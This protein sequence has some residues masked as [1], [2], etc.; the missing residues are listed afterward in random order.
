[1]EK[2][3]TRAF[4]AILL[5]HKFP[6]GTGEACEFAIKRYHKKMEAPI[7]KGEDARPSECWERWIQND[8]GLPGIQLPAG[9]WYKARLLIHEWLGSWRL[10]D[11][12]FSNGS[13]YF[14]T[15]G[16][17]SIEA[18][19]SA[20]V[21]ASTA[22]NF[23]NF[24]RLC[25][26]HKAL[27]R[28]A[29]NRFSTL[30]RKRGD[31]ARSVDRYLWNRFK[32]AKN[33]GFLCF[34][35]KL[36]LVTKIVHGSRFSTVPKNNEKVRPINIE[37]FANI[38][39]QKQVGNGIRQLLKTTVGID[40]DTLALEHRK[41]IKDPS[42]A[43]I[44]LS[45]ASDSVSIE[46][47]KFLFPGW[48][49][50]LLED[51]RSHMVLGP[52][53]NFHLTKKI[54][55]MG[56]GFTFELMTLILTA[57]CRTLD[58]NSSVFGDDIVID[59]NKAHLLISLLTE[60]GF[61]V[62]KEKS[63]T[64]GPFRESCGANWHDSFGYLRSYDFIYPKNIHD[65]VVIYNKAHH[66][67]RS[68]LEAFIGLEQRLRRAIPP[69]L[70]GEW[71][72]NDDIVMLDQATGSSPSLARYFRCPKGSKVNVPSLAPYLE[73]YKK[74]NCH[75][76]VTSLF[77]SYKFVPEERTP[78]RSHLR[79]SNWAK[80]EM[81]LHA[82]RRTKDVLTGCGEWV[83]TLMVTFD[84]DVTVEVRQVKSIVKRDRDQ[85]QPL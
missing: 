24:S 53:E 72:S 28:S 79:K 70:R 71:V 60:V 17:N 45:D 13:E 61:K 6:Q 85:I 38:L 83:S 20:S 44:D 22:L 16:R 67:A 5:N 76:E 37:P 73:Y 78:C 46:L 64:S 49:F 34:R 15:R 4:Q 21:W 66:L 82:G 40:L 27:K 81:Y 54:S 35:A 26:S 39:S 50:T 51:R 32:D 57:I 48:F 29:K 31:D 23:E 75:R 18:K 7:V 10:G 58:P 52:D 1:M 19:L 69:A 43:T 9:C 33:P 14:A 2:S 36:C 25:Y 12:D 30:I 77:F 63:F 62:N 59:K 8:N 65:C 3:T 84:H 47:V 42:V 68:G 80:Y 55:S 11:V 56:N 74:M 41:R